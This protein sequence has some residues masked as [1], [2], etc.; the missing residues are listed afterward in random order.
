MGTRADQNVPMPPPTRAV[1]L[2]A[3]GTLIEL[4]SP[5][6]PLQAAL[7]GDLPL[8]QVERA[9]RAE[10]AYYRAH[11]H[12]ADDPASLAALRESCA[13]LL[14][15]ELGREVPA[16]TMMSAIRFRAFPEA[17]GALADLRRRGV[18]LVCVSNWDCTLP[19]LLDE[20]GLAE[21]LDAVVV[22]ALAGSRKPEP[23]IFA[24]AL[25]RAGC[26]PGE[27]LHVGDSRE[28][29]LAGARGAGIRALL[30]QRDPV[31]TEGYES[32]TITSL[33]E[34]SDHLAT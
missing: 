24:S 18:R 2:D 12:E 6:A 14:A 3:L 13:E 20:L 25:K 4:E 31:S 34:I 26:G 16:E 5:F 1:L 21:L 7:G 8:E 22:S 10:M 27:A 17:H 9:M 23:E 29:D 28:E 11:S 32:A 15:R 30:L 19:G 33:V